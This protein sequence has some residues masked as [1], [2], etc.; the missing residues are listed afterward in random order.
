MQSGWKIFH[1]DCSDWIQTV[2]ESNF[3]HYF[4]ILSI[5]K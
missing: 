4:E 3:E 5:F 1:P 2:F